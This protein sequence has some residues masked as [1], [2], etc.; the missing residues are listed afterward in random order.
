MVAAK[1]GNADIVE[2]LLSVPGNEVNLQDKVRET[3][4]KA[5]YPF[6][7]IFTCCFFYSLIVCAE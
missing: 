4:Q 3:S 6:V 7:I 2:M 1:Y 5:S